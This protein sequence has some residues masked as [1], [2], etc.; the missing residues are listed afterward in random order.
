M[1]IMAMAKRFAT[2]IPYPD[3]RIQI[4]FPGITFL[5]VFVSCEKQILNHE[6]HEGARRLEFDSFVVKVSQTV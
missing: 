4:A 1:I 3:Q 2:E 5:P 6:V